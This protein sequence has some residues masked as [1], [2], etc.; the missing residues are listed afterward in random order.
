M[1]TLLTAVDVPDQGLA[2]FREAQPANTMGGTFT[3]GAWRTRVFNT[4]VSNTITGATL[5]TSTNVI[6]LPAG[7]YDIHWSAPGTSCAAHTSRLVESGASS[8]LIMGQG[9]LSSS[10]ST[11]MG[12]AYGRGRIILAAQTDVRVEHQ[13]AT[14]R[15]TDGLG[16]A[17]NID[18][19]IEVYAEIWIKR[20]L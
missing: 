18:S 10:A 2:H 1:S 20:I 12:S 16:R 3:S 17:A 11:T 7:T 8:T 6:T 15:A 4:T 13:C 19:Q 5:N 14:T 9:A